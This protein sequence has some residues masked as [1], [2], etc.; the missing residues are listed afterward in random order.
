MRQEYMSFGQ[1]GQAC[2][3]DDDC[4]SNIC[5][6]GRVHTFVEPM[7]TVSTAKGNAV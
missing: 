2:D 7:M 3:D 6:D 1:T 5:A 4:R